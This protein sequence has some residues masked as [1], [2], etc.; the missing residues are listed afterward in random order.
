MLFH[1]IM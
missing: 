1:L